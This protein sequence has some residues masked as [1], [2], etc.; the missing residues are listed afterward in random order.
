MELRVKQPEAVHHAIFM[1]QS[2]YYQ[3][4]KILFEVAEILT[5]YHMKKEVNQLAEFIALFNTRCFLNSPSVSSPRLYLER[6]WDMA[7]MKD[8]PD[9]GNKSLSSMAD[10]TF[11]TYIQLLYHF[12]W[13]MR[14]LMIKR[15]LKLQNRS[16][17]RKMMKDARMIS[18]MRKIHQ[19]CGTATCS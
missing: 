9:I 19:I 12:A 18:N 5:T 7:Y 4:I 3:K 16:Y 17:H 15:R 10:H 13:Q 6:I 11:G 8:Q 14:K 1:G 2:I